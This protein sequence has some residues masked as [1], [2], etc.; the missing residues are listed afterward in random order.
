[1][2]VISE[3]NSGKIVSTLL[4]IYWE[5]SR[6]RRSATT[7]YW[8]HSL[9][10]PNGLSWSLVEIHDTFQ[11][12]VARPLPIVFPSLSYS[13]S[14][15]KRTPLHPWEAVE[16]QLIWRKDPLVQY[17]P[18]RSHAKR[19]S[20]LVR[21]R[22]ASFVRSTRLKAC[23][24]RMPRQPFDFVVVSFS[25][26][27]QHI[28]LFEGPPSHRNLVRTDWIWLHKPLGSS[29][30]EIEYVGIDESTDFNILS[31]PAWP[32]YRRSIFLDRFY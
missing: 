2:R 31:F 29:K 24:S 16:E 17:F 26:A 15:P 28:F 7:K 1:M 14:L 22:Q 30:Q 11:I 13:T 21:M 10:G 9:L 3:A 8:S 19:M 20:G 32:I 6:E 27:I 18:R 4:W 5:V 25:Q 23:T 12:L